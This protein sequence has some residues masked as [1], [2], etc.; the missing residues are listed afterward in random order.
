MLKVCVDKACGDGDDKLVVG[1]EAPWKV[2]YVLTVF[3][4]T[5]TSGDAA[6]FGD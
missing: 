4:A 6:T 3:V 5:A 2:T 1:A